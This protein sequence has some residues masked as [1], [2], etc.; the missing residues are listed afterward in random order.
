M[1]SISCLLLFSG[2]STSKEVTAEKATQQVV[3]NREEM[4]KFRVKINAGKGEI[5]GV[6]AL[7]WIDGQ[8]RGSM[9]NEFGIKAFDLVASPNSC[10]LQQVIPFLNRWYIRKA[11]EA[12]LSFLLWEATQGKTTKGK[13]MR[14]PD[15]NGFVLENNKHHITYTFQLIE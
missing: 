4:S 1:L 2:C 13:T 8:W 3:L 10:K 11:I 7:K 6:L 9:I 14:F 12:D 15:P 5:T